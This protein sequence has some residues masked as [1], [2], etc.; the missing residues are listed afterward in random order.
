[1]SSQYLKES[2]KLIDDL[3]DELK[4]S[5]KDHNSKI[6]KKIV[7]E[8]SKLLKQICNDHNLDFDVEFDK[9]I[10]NKHR[11]KSNKDSNNRSESKLQN[12]TIVENINNEKILSKIIINKLEYWKDDSSEI[13]Y[14]S[15]NFK[16]VGLYKNNKLELHVKT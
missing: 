15:K 2:Y 4:K 11:K 16:E 3:N 7:S 5:L 14:D 6:K 13:L 8:K 9:Y 12:E 10:T 1:M